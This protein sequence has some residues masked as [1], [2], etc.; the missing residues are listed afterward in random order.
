M[1]KLHHMALDGLME[2]LIEGGAENIGTVFAR[3]FELAMQIERERFLGT[4][5]YKYCP[6]RQG[7]TNG[8]KAKRVDTPAGTITVNVPK[9][10]AHDENPF[11]PQ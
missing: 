7:Y 9:T 4:Q 5:P 1:D 10:A 2:Q 3:L 11:Y 6:S 8:Y